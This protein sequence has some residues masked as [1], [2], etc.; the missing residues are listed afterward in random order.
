MSFGR[1]K[2]KQDRRSALALAC[3]SE[4]S[5]IPVSTGIDWDF[6]GYALDRDLAELV[7]K[8]HPEFKDGGY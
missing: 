3:V 5:E 1:Q 6:V 8:Y 4:I 7:N 2:L